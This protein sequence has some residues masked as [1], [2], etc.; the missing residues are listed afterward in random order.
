MALE[1]RAPAAVAE[2]GGAPGR[3]DDVGEQHGRKHAVRGRGGAH[4]VRNFWIS[5]MMSVLDPASRTCGREPSNSTIR[6]PGNGGG[7]HA[8]G[9]R[10]GHRIA[11]AGA[12]R[13]SA[14]EI[15]ESAPGDVV[16]HQRLDSALSAMPRD[17]R[18][19]LVG[20][21]P[22]SRE[23]CWRCSGRG[24]PRFGPGPSRPPPRAC[25]RSSSRPAR[26]SRRTSPSPRRSRGPW[27]TIPQRMS[28]FRALGVGRREQRRRGATLGF[29]EQRRSLDTDRVHDNTHVLDALLERRK[30]APR[31]PT[32][33]SPPCRR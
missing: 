14:P 26:A 3:V 20:P 9:T 7:D 5:P 25:E 6:R 31:G 4:P 30:G 22:G 24:R 12:A 33:R 2:L 27:G 13:A 19:A 28:A 10:P 23:R 8:P 16:R 29:A 21:D 11:T 32:T 1:H 15:A 18:R 17:T